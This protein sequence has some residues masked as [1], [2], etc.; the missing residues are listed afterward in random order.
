MALA[1]GVLSATVT[2]TTTPG[3]TTISVRARDLAGNWSAPGT[4]DLV[5][6]ADP[7]GG[8]N[9]A[10]V[11]NAQSVSTSEDQAV[12][13]TLTAT[14][15]D[16]DPLT[17]RIVTPPEHGTLTGTGAVRTYTPAPDFDGSDSFT[18]VADDGTSESAPASVDVTVVPVNDAPTVQVAPI[19]PTTEGSVFQ[20]SALLGDVDDDPLTVDWQ[21]EPRDDV[22]GGAGCVISSPDQSSTSATCDDDGT[23]AFIVTVSD[24]VA[25][26]EATS[27]A[28]VTN[29]A[30]VPTI[31]TAPTPPV[32]RGTPITIAA[33]IDDPGAN[34]TWLC[35]IDWGDGTSSPGSATG[36]ECSGSHAYAT[37]GTFDVVVSVTDD[38]L[39][40]ATA[41]TSVTVTN[42]APVATPQTV[43]TPEDTAVG[44][45]LG[46]SDPDG[47]PLTFAIVDPPSN[48]TLTGS[49][50]ARTYTPA[51]DA[52]GTDS[53]TFSVSDGVAP[54][55]VA[56]VGVTVSPVDD[57]PTAGDVSGTAATGEPASLALVGSD[58]DGDDLT[59]VVT[60]PPANGTVTVTGSTAV[61]TSAPGFAGTDTFR[62][63]ADDG[64]AQS[65]P[66]TVTVVVTAAS[67]TVRLLTA[68]DASR[69]TGVRPLDGATFTGGESIFAFVDVDAGVDVRR[70]SFTVDGVAF[71][72]DT[73][74]PFDLAGTGWTRACRTCP[75]RAHPFES[76]L[77]GLGTHDIEASVLL[78]S[79]ERI[80]VR[81]EITVSDTE[82]HSLRF[83]TSPDRRDAVALDGATVR[84]RV[85]PVL[86]PVGD[87]IAGLLAVV[88]RLDGRIIGID[89][90][91][92]YDA[93]G[94]GWLGL[95]RPIDTRELR[96]GGHVL[97]AEVILD[98]LVRVEYEARFNVVR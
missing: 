93:V 7:G 12:D 57:A 17:Y 46:G 75:L 42:Q 87:P 96:T 65:G 28:V 54:P 37:L 84:G 47:D 4:A 40:T 95:A 68:D 9:R 36:D 74:A 6:V 55:V 43:T 89:W 19:V 66:A 78:R 51:P 3:T 39:A 49:G 5:V 70:V 81:A 83:S 92:P 56:T 58:V 20:L 48:G 16:G 67:S 94:S 10:P 29:R 26:T 32:F 45:T 35:S 72:V 14:D 1:A 30:P 62:Y 18:F 24:G 73:R 21:V 77:L 44:V 82:P 60:E 13:V 53:F 31:V 23:W 50:A 38:D 63:V 90:T 76:N 97:T 27:T 64:T 71:S 2:D 69:L 22:D 41:T 80:V 59:F 86:G 91:D 61:Y 34:D 15:A 52:H 25:Q 98:G 11:A 85:Y 33:R 88:F 8:G 79:G